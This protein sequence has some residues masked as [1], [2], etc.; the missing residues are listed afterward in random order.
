VSV[1]ASVSA[2]VG[3][4]LVRDVLL[5]DG[6]T[7]R[8]QAPMPA[9]FQDIKAFYDGL[10]P[11]SRYLRF[12]GYAR[13]DLAARTDVEAAGVDRLALIARHDGRVVAAARYEGLREP[14]VAE[15]A[16]AVADELQRHGIGT[17]MLE[18]LAAVAAERGIHR[19]DAE[20]V[21]GNALMLDVFEH[22]GFAV[23]RRA[24][25]G[26]VTVSLDIAPTRAV[27][28]RID[29]RDHFA[30]IAS[31]RAVLAPSSVAVLGAGATRGS[32]G[33]RV[34]ANI[35]GGGFQGVVMPVNRDGGVVCSIAAAR[36]LGELPVVPDL[37]IVAASGEELLEFAAEV[38]GSGAR[39]M[40]VIS[41]GPEEDS[42][43]STVREERLLEIVRGA[44][45]RLVGPHSLGVVNTDPD[46]SLN[47]T[48]SGAS[49]SPGALGICS[50]SAAPGVG[51][52][53]HAAAR[54]LGVSILVSLGDRA[55][56]STND[57]LEYFEE[58]EQTAAVILYLETF[59]NPEHF[60]RIAQRVSRRKPILALKGRRY[61]ESA[62]SDL[63]SDTAAALRG[64]AVV[65]ALLHQAGVLRLRSGEELFDA[66]EFFACQPLPS[67]RQIGIITNSAG[68]ATLATD[69]CA[70]RGL[71]I[72]QSTTVPN[73]LVFAVSASANEYAA[74]IP[75][76]LADPGIDA[77]MVCYVD[78]L[79][80]PDT[81]LAATST[82]S[83]GQPKPVV[84]SIVRSDGQLPARGTASVPNFLFP[85]SCAA[86]LARA[87]ERREWLSRPLGERP[88]YDD[89]QSLPAR[90]VISTFLG[91]EPTGG[92][93]TLEEGDALLGTHGIPTVASHHCRSREQAIAAAADLAGPVVLKAH[94]PAPAHASD[95][96]A[97][98]L[99]LEGQSAIRS[100]WRE[101]Q[102]RV[103]A[104][105]QAWNGAIIQ[106]FAPGGANVLLGAVVDSDLGLALA[107]GL[108]GR[109]ARLSQTAQFRLAPETDT[110]AD[111]LIDSCAGVA[112]QLDPFQG[113]AMLDRKALRE[114]IL[115]FA[116]L[117][118]NTPEIAEAD[119]NPVR[120][121]THGC[122]VLDAQLRIQ[123]PHQIERAKT[124]S[125]RR[126]PVALASRARAALSPLRTASP[127][128]ASELVQLLT[129]ARKLG[130]EVL[131]RTTKRRWRCPDHRVAIDVTRT[132]GG[133]R[134]LHPADA[135]FKPI[136]VEPRRA[137]VAAH[138]ENPPGT[139]PS[140]GAG[141]LADPAP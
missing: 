13:A 105:G 81:V 76:L 87:A 141:D 99:G 106:P 111:E 55:D 115:R 30:A 27:R 38:G 122:V 114:L 108:G 35:L 9:D 126:T 72:A 3:P 107:V 109:Q 44:G 139:N 47:A 37:V 118:Q 125:R 60:T 58:N 18:Q 92:W 91:R 129:D 119:L 98:L 97:V 73:P 130:L 59:G 70:T 138:G 71:E 45:L 28:E 21:A 100:A 10:S 5:R 77:L 140:K 23:R 67:G 36:S 86:V 110:E 6:S 103:R 65:D 68:V 51:L 43:R 102:H 34:L 120:C 101:A 14:G 75:A 90:A 4:R 39:A 54:R 69:A 66:A 113:R 25:S 127:G 2:P 83:S 1:L 89:L 48:F 15:V 74:S 17:R 57:L 128:T 132:Q 136:A 8:L 135:M 131:D 42:D 12:H 11:E 121:T 46:V 63:Q 29:E 19:F 61:V 49:V 93:L 94:L 33:R 22:A 78:L 50:Q 41:A 26:E 96:D 62:R 88:H 20:V 31:L 80:D 116:L 40:L 137:I 52:L 56:V 16:F 123:P 82:A 7:L 84:A 134:Q 24:Y 112:T 95:I 104:A 85:D 124:W 53:G 117:L 32:L 133:D 64:D 79:D